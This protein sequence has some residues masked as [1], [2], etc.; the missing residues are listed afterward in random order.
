MEKEKFINTSPISLKKFT[1]YQPLKNKNLFYQLETDLI[2]ENKNQEEAN[3][4]FNYNEFKKGFNNKINKE[5]KFNQVNEEENYYNDIPNELSLSSLKYDSICQCCKN[6]FYNEKC[7][8]YLLKCGHI[9]CLNCLNKY[10]IGQKGIECPTDGIIAHSINDLKL[11]KNINSN[12]KKTFNRLMKKKNTVG[13]MNHSLFKND[14]ND[15]NNNNKYF[16]NFS[17]E[18]SIYNNYQSN[19]CPIHE[20]QKLSHIVNDT[21]ELIC[22]HCAFERIKANPNILIMEIKEKYIEY[23]DMIENI[24]NKIQKNIELINNTMNLI[25]KNKE[26]E[27][28]KLNNFY[29]SIIKYIEMQK[30]EKTQQIE[31]ISKENNH[32]LELKILLF[33]EFIEKGKKVQKKLKKD[34]NN[35]SQEFSIIFNDYNNFMKLKESLFDDKLNNKLKYM[36]FKSKSEI[37][38]KEYLNKIS[39]LCIEIRVINYTKNIKKEIENKNTNT[40]TN[41]IV[42][43][44]NES[45]DKNLTSLQYYKI[46]ATKK[47]N[48]RNKLPKISNSNDSLMQTYSNEKYKT[49]DPLYYKDIN[50]FF[51][52]SEINHSL[53]INRFRNKLNNNIK[54]ANTERTQSF[55]KKE[56]DINFNNS[57]T[58]KKEKNN[59]LLE[60]Y[61][62]FKKNK[63]NYIGSNRKWSNKN[64]NYKN[65]KTF[66][67]LN[68]LNN[69]YSLNLSKKHNKNNNEQNTKIGIIYLSDKK[70]YKKSKIKLYNESLGKLIPEQLKK[71]NKTLNFNY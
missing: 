68:I 42:K 29:D 27:I 60:N 57:I 39:D 47:I 13:N 6:K 8:L 48:F 23:N 32:D 33:N 1:K 12:Q 31:N 22:V 71:I 61:F 69:F 38:V 51:K 54:A 41:K 64:K 9:F 66:N 53:E 46:M 25:S 40:N 43:K 18:N 50:S 3:I 59:C 37:N 58:S 65:S 49:N 19:Y 10:F 24:I 21:N 56:I 14:N 4:N 34:E 16:E 26:N 52:N 30:S 36:R 45:L 5:T 55:L 63:K 17:N 11:L 28:K 67:N 7:F 35:C 2:Q 20:T 15:Y 62:R 44:D 70:N